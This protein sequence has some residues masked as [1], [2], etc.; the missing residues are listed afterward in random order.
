MMEYLN[1]APPNDMVDGPDKS[2]NANHLYDWM[3]E[4]CERLFDNEIEQ[5]AFED[6]MRLMFGI[7][8]AYKLFTVDKLIGVFIKQVSSLKHPV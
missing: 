2:A 4:S 7:K 1:L 6:Q 8:E 5:S 3:L